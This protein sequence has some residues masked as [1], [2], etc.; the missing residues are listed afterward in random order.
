MLLFC[1][2]VSYETILGYPCF[3]T[4]WRYQTDL[5][6]EEEHKSLKIARIVAK[7]SPN[8]LSVSYTLYLFLY[9]LVNE[10]RHLKLA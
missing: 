1:A 4:I 2:Y 7:T 10:I 5:Y 3:G 6:F 8:M 9:V